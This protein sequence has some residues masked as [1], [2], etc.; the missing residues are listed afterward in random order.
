MDEDV[1]QL[2]TDSMK[3]SMDTFRMK[4]G[5]FLNRSEYII[6]S[7]KEELYDTAIPN[8]N[9]IFLRNT[10]FYSLLINDY[11][12]AMSSLEINLDV[13]NQLFAY[14]ES[15]LWYITSLFE[16]LR[17]IVIKAP[18]KIKKRIIKEKLNYLTKAEKIVSFSKAG[19]I[20]ICNLQECYYNNLNVE[21][22]D[23][24]SNII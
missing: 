6:K 10:A 13:V 5:I 12:L 9:S 24:I 18:P 21:K 17:F 2:F 22:L 3:F 11:E 19:N 1:L 16:V 23:K 20:Q 14:G 15:Y 8:P 4:D 7:K